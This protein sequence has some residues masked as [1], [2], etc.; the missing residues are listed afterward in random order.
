MPLP[1]LTAP[2]ERRLWLIYA[3]TCAFVFAFADAVFAFAAAVIF[4]DARRYAIITFL[5]FVI[6]VVTL[7]SLR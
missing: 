3:A 2:D 4:D 6:D 1:L 5:A 7:M